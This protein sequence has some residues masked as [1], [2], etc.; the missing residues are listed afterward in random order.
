LALACLLGD[1]SASLIL[2]PAAVLAQEP[3]TL[4]FSVVELYN[5]EQPNKRGVLM[6]RMSIGDRRLRRRGLE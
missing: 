3:R 2:R 5:D 4:G 6:V 1:L